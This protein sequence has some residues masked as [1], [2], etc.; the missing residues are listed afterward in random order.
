MPAF[1]LILDGAYVIIV[2]ITGIIWTLQSIG[3]RLFIRFKIHGPLG[4]DDACCV[5][6]S[7][8]AIT[9]SC[10]TVLGTCFGLGKR[11]AEISDATLNQQRILAYIANQFYIASLSFSMLSITFLIARVTR[12]TKQVRWAYAVATM[13][14][15]WAVTSMF[16]LAFDCKFPK[17]WNHHPRSRC[18]NVVRIIR[19]F[20]PNYEHH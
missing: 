3:I 12:R 18:H 13:T 10:I 7:V 15:L 5:V 20:I 1:G 14:S 11:Q 16:Y 8:L 9:H 19:S 4:W 2:C 17:P 6:A